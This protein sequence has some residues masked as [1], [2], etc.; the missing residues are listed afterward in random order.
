MKSAFELYLGLVVILFKDSIMFPHCFVSG[1][2]IA[3]KL[4]L[5]SPC[6][7]QKLHRQGADIVQ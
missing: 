1:L 2:P 3:F 6:I 4:S 5:T 7:L